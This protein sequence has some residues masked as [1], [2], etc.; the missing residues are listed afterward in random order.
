V[1]PRSAPSL[2]SRA[3]ALPAV[4]GLVAALEGQEPPARVALVG[5]ALR[6]LILG[7]PVLDV[8]I[9]VE[10]PLE[11]VLRRLGARPRTHD[12]FDTATVQLGGHQLDLARTRSE[13]YAQP[14]ALPEVRPASLPED[15]TRRDFTVN[16]LA[17]PLLGAQAGQLLGAA[18]AEADL[19]AGQL[20]IL[21]PESFLDDPTRLLRLARYRAR[22]GFSVEAD[23]L[24]AARRAVAAGALGTISGARIAS[25]LALLS[26]EADPVAGWRALGCL[27]LDAAIEPGFGISD[28]ELARRALGLLPADGRPGVVLMALALG[29]VPA[30]TRRGL[31]DRLALGGR[32]RDDVLAVAGGAA[33]LAG[34]LR[35]ADRPS[36]IARAVGTPR[37]PELVAVAGA[38]GAEPPARRWLEDLRHVR[39]AIDGDDLLAAGVA[40]GPGLGAGL[41]A[42]RAALLDGRAPSRQQQLE[43]AL[44]VAREAE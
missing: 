40:P 28:P 4:A 6:D 15:L 26:A 44:R 8:D 33:E 41:A 11:P 23:T 22:L 37:A 30:Q 5:G 17:L 16:A 38:L 18:Q 31:L 1:H 10:G 42:A 35:R 21:H 36:E 19:Q 24:A 20:R 3:R 27:G 13:T 39:L 29:G 34:E 14:G 2:L 7:R 25:E 9:A 43:E 12:R 32:E